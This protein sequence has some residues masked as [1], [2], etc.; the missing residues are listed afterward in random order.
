MR[1]HTTYLS[2]SKDGS[3]TCPSQG[4]AET[5][6]LGCVYVDPPDDRSP[7]GTAAVTSWWV[8]DEAVGS[9]L[10]RT[11]DALVPVWLAETWGFRS[12]QRIP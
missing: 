4:N 6:L 9:E 10:E 2:R 3:P 8:V 7:A 12:V 11:L 5:A 1:H